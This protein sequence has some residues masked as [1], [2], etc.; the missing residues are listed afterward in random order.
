M[1]SNTHVESKSVL[2]TVY[3]QTF[4]G[5]HFDSWTIAPVI[6]PRFGRYVVLRCETWYDVAT[7]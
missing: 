3:S 7:A 2:K 4:P 5:P 1:S 6:L